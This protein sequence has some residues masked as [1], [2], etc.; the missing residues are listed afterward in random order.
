[1]VKTRLITGAARN[2]IDVGSRTIAVL[3]NAH[4]FSPSPDAC[5][6]VVGLIARKL[7]Q[8]RSILLANIP[9]DDRSAP[10][11]V[12]L[13]SLDIALIVLAFQMLHCRQC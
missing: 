7:W 10:K 11:H 5:V 6:S 2:G 12:P 13:R 8:G 3:A 4:R 9:S 1:M